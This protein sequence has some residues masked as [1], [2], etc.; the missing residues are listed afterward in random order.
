MQT[1]YPIHDMYIRE[2]SY[3]EHG[4]LTRLPLLQYDDHLLRR[5]GYAEFI[6][7]EPGI[8]TDTPPRQVADEVWALVEGRVKFT[9]KD[10]RDHSP[11][12]NIE[13]EIMSDK[14]V[15]LLIPFG[16]AFGY[17]VHGDITA[18][19]IRFATHTP[20]GSQTD[21]NPLQGHTR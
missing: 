16:V 10:T 17:E 12:C 1:E 19:L 20:A 14:P 15:L 8:A 11:T 21:E 13:H 7:A 5:F 9:W 2:L 3:R 18:L 6:R 4:D